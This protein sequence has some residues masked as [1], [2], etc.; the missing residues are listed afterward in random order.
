[1]PEL[2]VYYNVNHF[3][4]VTDVIERGINTK[5]QQSTKRKISSSGSS[6]CENDCFHEDDA[7]DDDNI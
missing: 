4:A 5:R 2:N 6:A 3:A 1:M 7:V